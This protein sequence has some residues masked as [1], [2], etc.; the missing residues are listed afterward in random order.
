MPEDHE[1]VTADGSR[2]RDAY[3]DMPPPATSAEVRDRL[4]HLL[5]RDLVGPHPD[6]DPDLAREV[7]AD[8][9]P[10]TWYL[11]GF[12]APAG[13]APS[14]PVPEDFANEEAGEA[15]IEELRETE[16]LGESAD[17]SGHDDDAPAEPPRRSF[18]PSSLGLTVL[19]AEGTARIEARATWGDYR[20]EPPLREALFLPER[21]EE[22]EQG[23][24]GLARSAS[25]TP[26]TAS[27]ER[28]A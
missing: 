7:L 21:S 20:P 9:T 18:L 27:L 24:V 17:A 5:R 3:A 13:D 8:A 6:L 28:N 12:L 1:S 10:S 4:V 2:L 25:S 26:G 23:E 15:G 22:I 19:V 16:T 11:T 14:A